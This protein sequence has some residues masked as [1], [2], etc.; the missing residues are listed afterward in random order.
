MANI[1]LL[2]QTGLPPSRVG[3]AKP[4]FAL[5]DRS[6]ERRLGQVVAGIGNEKWAQLLDSK[7]A[8]EKAL[9]L[10]AEKTARER[11]NTFIIEN[12]F[13]NEADIRKAQGKMIT[14]IETAGQSSKLSAVKN[15]ATNW[16][17]QNKDVLLQKSGNDITEIIKRREQKN[18]NAQME[19]YENS[20][21]PDDTDKA[22]ALIDNHT[23]SLI[24]PELAPVMKQ[25]FEQNKVNQFAKIA[26]AQEKADQEA[27]KDSAMG[28]AFNLWQSTVTE[29]NPEGD[30]NTAF[31]FIQSDDRISN[32]DKQEVESELKTRV[33]S[34]LAEDRLAIDAQRSE[35]L[36]AINN[37]IF[38]DKNYDAAM[39]AIN[40]SSLPEKEQRTLFADVEK[41]A[42]AA[43]KGIPL[44]N[45]RVEEARLYELSL[46]I[47]RGAT[48]KKDFDADLLKNSKKLDDPAYKRV[49][50]SAA[51]TLK[52]SQAEALSRSH[53]ETARLIVDH[54]EDDAFKAFISAS[55]KGL[56]PD[57]AS[58]FQ[59]N[60]NEDRQLQFWSLSQYD[61]ELR[62]WIE[63]N[64]NKLGKEFFQFEEQL[65]H[66]YWNKSIEDLRTSRVERGIELSGD[67]SVINTQ[68]E[69]DA[70]KSG[71]R[72]KDTNGNI[73]TK[74]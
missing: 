8:N 36:D 74:P 66:Q 11:L 17:A 42:T 16:M 65:K 27:N 21:D 45:D 44:T 46:D 19:L 49:S 70:L 4:S 28:D 60:A 63:D 54:K 57:A 2:Q 43:A 56:S 31:D 25:I 18:F 48:T 6:G 72:Y 47:W 12:P 52:S 30:L 34:R 22:L 58:L 37:L 14:E 71:T 62:Q 61:A 10:G 53:A 23:G 51:N 29:E 73:G 32:D 13:A 69:Y 7:V 68:A 67:V 1:P 26:A 59:D 24:D 33:K 15:Y 35:D 3:V 38:F 50:A 20:I 41:R 64:P 55:I 5:A 40:V 39:T 9:F